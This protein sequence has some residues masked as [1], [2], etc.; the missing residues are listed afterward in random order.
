MF[1]KYQKMVKKIL[2]LNISF[3]LSYKIIF[4]LLIEEIKVKSII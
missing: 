3:N 2:S 4:L 1:E